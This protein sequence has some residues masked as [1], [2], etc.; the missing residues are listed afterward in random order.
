MLSP[1]E[2]LLSQ[3]NHPPQELELLDLVH[4]NG[5]RLQK[6]VNTLLDFSRI[7]AGRIQADYEPADLASVTGNLA[8]NFRSA[9]EKAGLAFK[10]D[11]EPLPEPVYIDRDMWEKVVLNLLSNALKF[12]LAGSVTISLRVREG[13]AEL[14]VQDTG[15]G[16][17][18][19][20]LPHIFE[21]FRRVA[22]ARGRSMEGTG[23]GL[24][25][26][27]ELVKLHSGSITHVC[28]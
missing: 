13:Q 1:V 25:L 21:R 18:E 2:E 7:E 15:T 14:T 9:M 12:T 26:V 3:K 28:G 6:L 17:P 16:I 19:S 10:I 20:E 11:C 4:R 24:A 5:L 22:G 23:I 27:Q 8:S